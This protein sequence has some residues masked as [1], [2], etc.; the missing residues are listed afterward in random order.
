M[1]QKRIHIYQTTYQIKQKYMHLEIL[2][3]Y[4]YVPIIVLYGRKFFVV[5]FILFTLLK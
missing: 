2:Q 3:Q 4:Y 5:F 1:I